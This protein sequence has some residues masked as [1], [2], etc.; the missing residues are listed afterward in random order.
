[1]NWLHKY[2][3]HLKRMI[4]NNWNFAPI[5]N[6]WF[7]CANIQNYTLIKN[8]VHPLSLPS[9]YRLAYTIFINVFNTFLNISEIWTIITLKCFNL[10]FHEKLRNLGFLQ[11]WEF[12]C[13][14]AKAK[15]FN[16]NLI[17]FFFAH[18]I[19]RIIV[20][21]HLFNLFYALSS[22][23]TL[24]SLRFIK[25]LNYFPKLL[26]FH[27]ILTFIWVNFPILQNIYD[28]IKITTVFFPILIY[29]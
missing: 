17:I 11:K 15:N 6:N 29:G 21:Q 27:K 2:I 20:F 12:E 24:V 10:S 8:N 16:Y 18:A 4:K 23:Q 19:N 22:C 1:M 14:F 7:K 5:I 25:F 9:R 13:S 28:K 3:S 26:Q